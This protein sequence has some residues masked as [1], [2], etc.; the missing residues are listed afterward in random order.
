MA[1][2]DF[3]H[4]LSVDAIRFVDSFCASKK[5]GIGRGRQVS[6]WDA[7]HMAAALA[8]CRKALFSTGWTIS[9]LVNTNRLNA[10]DIKSLGDNV[11]LASE[12]DFL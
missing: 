12:K 11:H 3:G 4:M 6:A 8:S 1:S 5:G 10:I 7:V 9:H 2:S